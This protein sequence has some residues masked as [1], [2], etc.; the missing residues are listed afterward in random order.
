MHSH[1]KFEEYL[2]KKFHETHQTRDFMKH[3]LHQWIED[4][5]LHELFNHADHWCSLEVLKNHEC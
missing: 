2:H 1:I 5:P 3:E 4:M